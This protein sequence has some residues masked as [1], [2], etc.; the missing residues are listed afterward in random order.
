MTQTNPFP[1]P[2]LT[3]TD[4]DVHAL[5]DEFN[6][7][8]HEAIRALL[9]DLAVLAQDCD[10]SVSYGYVRGQLYENSLNNNRRKANR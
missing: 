7:N 6:G 3:I 5:L 8:A 10:L 9:H 2:S 4:E 1:T